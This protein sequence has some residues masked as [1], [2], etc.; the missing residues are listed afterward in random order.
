MTSPR[1]PPGKRVGSGDETSLVLL[2][3]H[4]L[5]QL[6]KFLDVNQ[7]RKQENDAAFPINEGSILSVITQLETSF[8]VALHTLTQ[9]YGGCEWNS[10]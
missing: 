3:V 10:V 6:E 9:Q 2:L 8:S 4:L 5:H 7:I 1:A